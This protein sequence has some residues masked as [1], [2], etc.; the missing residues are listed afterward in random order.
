MQS[1]R[2]HRPLGSPRLHLRRTDSTNERARALAASGAPHGTLVTAEEQTAGRGRQGR[3]W[4]APARSALLCSLVVRD[5]PALLSLIAGIAVC[6][7]IGS[8]AQVKWPNDIVTGHSLTKLAGILVEGRP[9]ESWAVVGIG[10]NVAVH[11]DDLPV[12]LRASAA[13]LG[14]PSSAIETTMSRVLEALQRHLY[15]P[16]ATV[17][18]AWRARDALRGREVSWGPPRPNGGSRPGASPHNR[19]RAEGI[20]QD[21]RLIVKLADGGSVALDAGEVHLESAG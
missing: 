8:Q 21:G 13:S 12:E 7:A 4:T 10:L 1:D 18:D 2:T 11:I 5:P 9:Q 20:D 14:L 17:L 6:D 15:E 19:G 3:S 16:A